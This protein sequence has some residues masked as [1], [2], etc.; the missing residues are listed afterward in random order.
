MLVHNNKRSLVAI[1]LTKLS[2][3][4]EELATAK[5]WSLL[6]RFEDGDYFCNMCVYIFLFGRIQKMRS[7]EHDAVRKQAKTKEPSVNQIK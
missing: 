6:F 4:L 7:R 5:W 1:N 3:V 2:V